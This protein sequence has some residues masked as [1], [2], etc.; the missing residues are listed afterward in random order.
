M[1]DDEILNPVH[2]RR[3]LRPSLPLFGGLKIWEANAK[4][5]EVMREGGALLKAE[6]YPHSYMHCWR[7]KT[8]IIYRATSAVVRRHGRPSR[9]RPDAARARAGRHRGDAVLPRPGARRGCT[10]DR[11]PARLD[12]VAPAPVGRA[13]GVLRAPRDR[14]AAPAHARSCSSRS[15]SGSNRAA[16]KPGRTLDPR[17][18]LGDEAAQYVKNRDTLDVW[19]DSGSTHETVLR[20]SHA[21]ECTSRPR[22]TSR[23]RTSTAAG[24]TRRC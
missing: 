8:P 2:G 6:K 11:E 20:G 24:S 9:R 14:R 1:T 13:D 7:H 21:A 23:A 10:D 15:R 16:S 17:E 3:P 4:I 19:F 18:L 12:A 5:V 22:C